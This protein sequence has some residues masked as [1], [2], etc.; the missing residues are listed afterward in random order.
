[1]CGVRRLRLWLALV[2]DPVPYNLLLFANMAALGLWSLGTVV[3]AFG[4]R[5]VP[6]PGVCVMTTIQQKVLAWDR[7]YFRPLFFLTGLHNCIDLLFTSF[8]VAHGTIR[9]R[10]RRVAVELKERILLLICDMITST[11]AQHPLP[12]S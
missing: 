5:G 1:M 8:I 11:T 7:R 10:E 3:V 2:R 4:S 9:A 12:P 6:G